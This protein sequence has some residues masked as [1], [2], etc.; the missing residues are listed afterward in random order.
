MSIEAAKQKLDLR[1]NFESEG[2]PLHSLIE[3][4]SDVKH[5]KSL[6][7]KNA[8]LAHC[9]NSEGFTS[10][11]MVISYLKNKA[12]NRDL[13]IDLE[14]LKTLVQSK[15]FKF[16]VFRKTK[17]EGIIYFTFPYKVN[18]LIEG[19]GQV[20]INGVTKSLTDHLKEALQISD[21]DYQALMSGEKK[22]KDIAK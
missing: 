11:D 20:T 14:I 1:K 15:T 12:L 4:Q 13:S 18:E 21:K 10:I 9:Y 6:L 5:I 17:P 8:K 7:E 22:W 3:H 19:A 2:S 16:T